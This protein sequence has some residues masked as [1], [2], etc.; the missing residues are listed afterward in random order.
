MLDIAPEQLRAV[1]DI[2]QLHAPGRTVRFFGS[3]VK[4]DAKPFSDLDL[5]VMGSSPLGF[6]R[7]TELREAF[8]ESCLPF[9]V[10]IVDWAETSE[11]FRDIIEEEFEEYVVAAEVARSIR[12]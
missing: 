7:L 8:S 10:D 6:R 9:R 11:M 5:A 2:L 3:R 1:L 4:G 12:Q